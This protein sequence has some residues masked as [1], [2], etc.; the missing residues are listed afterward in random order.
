MVTRDLVHERIVGGPYEAMPPLGA[1][2]ARR[3]GSDS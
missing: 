2:I 1:A 3:D